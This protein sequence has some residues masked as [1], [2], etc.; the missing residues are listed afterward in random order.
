MSGTEFPSADLSDPRLAAHALSP[1]P[2]WLWSADATRILW[3]NPTAASIFNAA[4]PAAVSTLRFEPNHPAAVQIARLAGTLPPG[5]AARLERLRGF[6]ASVGG[7]LT[8]L[9][10]RFIPRDNS[11]AVLVISTERAGPDITLP[12]RARRLL[13]D[14][15]ESAIFSADGELIEAGATARQRL[16]AAADL[17]ALGAE[18]L[19]REASTNGDAEGDIA[20]GR[21]KLRR[22]GAGATVALMLTFIAPV[23]MPTVAIGDLRPIRHHAGMA[24]PKE[25]P[26]AAAAPPPQTPKP[27]A[28]PSSARRSILRFV[29]QI[30]EAGRFTVDSE[31][32]AKLIGPKTA[33]LFGRPWTDDRRRAQAR[34]QGRGRQGARLAQHL[35]RHCRAVAD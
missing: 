29:W 13:V 33:S 25:G 34:S 5:A 8:C 16:P 22:L 15:S 1:M 20:L 3:A 17:G 23:R 6:G 30:D 32:F 14:D 24:P 2:V 4:S 27:P 31:Q 28:P 21:V 10:S 26:P 7:T 19:A 35:E 18:K 9:C 11:A 12:D